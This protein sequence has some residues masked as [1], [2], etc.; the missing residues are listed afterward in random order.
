M[1]TKEQAHRFACD[2]IECWNAHD[3]DR[4]LA[5]YGDDFEM[6]SPLIVDLMNEPSGTLR[7]KGA[8]R[9]YWAKALARQPRSRF[10]LID[11]YAGANSVVIHYRGPRG[12]GTE[13][14]WFDEHGQVYRAAAHY[15]AAPALSAS[16]D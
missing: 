2:W 5:H 3:L 10:E 11:A 1:I 4:I 7:G 15:I 12:L 14:F 6:S 8:V 9:S 16:G 13:V